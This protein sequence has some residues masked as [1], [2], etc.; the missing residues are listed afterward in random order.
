MRVED[1]IE[2]VKKGFNYALKLGADEV[3]AYIVLNKRLS[4]E[5]SK[6]IESFKSTSTCWLSLRAA[7]GRKTSIF[8]TTN[9]SNRGV[10]D[11]VETVV[12]S[13][14]ASKED[15]YWHG[16]AKGYSKTDV[17][18]L[19]DKE[20]AR[21]EPREL[22]ETYVRV[23]NSALEVN[24]RVEL[25]RGSATTNTSHTIIL[26]SY[27]DFVEGES[28]N[29]SLWV[30]VAIREGGKE[31]IGEEYDISRSLNSLRIEHVGKS[32]AEK[33]VKFLGAKPIT[34]EKMDLILKN[35]VAASI[36]SIMLGGP[37]SANWVQEGRSP[38]SNKINSKVAVEPLTILDDA[39]LPEGP[40]SKSFDDE[41]IPT[42]KNVVL[43]NGVLKTFL[44]DTYTAL[45][46]GKQSTGNAHRTPYSR[47][48]PAPNCLLVRGGD[49][50][51]DEIVSETKRGLLVIGTIGEWLS[52]PVSGQLNATVTQG[53]L[54]E[55]GEEKEKV[56]GVVISGDFWE[57]LRNHVNMIGRDVELSFH[58]T[59]APT[60]RISNVTIAGK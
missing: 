9:I 44:Y 29:T 55:N 37:L 40:F 6:G 27:G 28:T 48:Q 60:L 25:V 24:S 13:A 57:L 16:F 50:A 3:E 2:R 34:T 26:N 42:R 17:E 56:K 12:S 41:G 15:P 19:Y 31:S 18:G 20:T 23:E 59:Y 8:S 54:I 51:F 53:V 45:R 58:N 32:A 36:L 49:A 4:I 39:T 7:V 14:K 52:N 33:A 22:V 30:Q 35:K 43:E 46:E 1:I 5:F 21:L 11:A 47:P 38:L 10:K